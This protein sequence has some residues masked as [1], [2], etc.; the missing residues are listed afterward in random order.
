MVVL[1]MDELVTRYAALCVPKN[2]KMTIKPVLCVEKK[3]VKLSRILCSIDSP[4]INHQCLGL[5]TG[6]SFRNIL[7]RKCVALE[8]MI[9]NLCNLFRISKRSVVRCELNRIIYKVFTNLDDII[10]PL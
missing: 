6:W 3:L 10:I 9:L 5:R 7:I 2:L 1:Y 8:V 4:Y